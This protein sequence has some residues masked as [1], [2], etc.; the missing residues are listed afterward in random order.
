M[1]ILSLADASFKFAAFSAFTV[2][3]SIATAQDVGKK[4][5]RPTAS[6]IFGTP[7]IDGEID[8]A[9]NS[10]PAVEV[11]KIAKSETSMPEADVATGTVKLMWDKDYLYA[12]WQVKDSKLSTK[13]DNAYE[14]DSIEL[15][16]DELHE[17]AG[18]YQKDDV[19]YRVSCE[20][21]LSGAGEG[22]KEENLKAAVKRID[23]GYLVEMSVRLSFAK[24]EGGTKM[25]LELQLNDDPGTGSRGGVSKWNHAENDSYQD[26]SN[27]GIVLLKAKTE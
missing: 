12:L 6:A 15:F 27:F 13:A 2:F 26:T 4:P 21:K 23:G 19:Q 5:E 9:W 8:D 3:V 24:R 16:V 10:V 11:K 14:Q 25:G 18:A 1:R 22:Y 17:R 7:K 20:G